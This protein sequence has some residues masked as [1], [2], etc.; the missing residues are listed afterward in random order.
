MTSPHVHIRVQADQ[1]DLALAAA[2]ELV[3]AVTHLQR[4]QPE[5]RLVLTGGGA[6][7][8]TLRHLAALDHAAV[9]SAEDFPTERI[10]WNRVLIFFGDERFLPV[11]DPERND[12]QADEALLNHVSIPDHRVFRYSSPEVSSLDDAATAYAATVREQAPEGFDIH[13]L[14]MGPEGHINSLFPHTPELMNP[15][16]IVVPVRDCPKPP[17]ER[18]S[19]S[20]DAVGSADEVWLLV[21]GGAKAEAAAKVAAGTD[22]EYLWPAALASGRKKTLLWVDKEA[23]AGL[24]D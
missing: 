12:T 16:D 22:E 6:G 8:A 17:P 19:L 18:V 9:R 14:G 3:H 20:I 21:A 23:A 13:L 7:I 15:Q 5:V 24:S 4:T 11:G 1:N 10:D 2:R